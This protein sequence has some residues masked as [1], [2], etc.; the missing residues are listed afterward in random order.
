MIASGPSSDGNKSGDLKVSTGTSGSTGGTLKLI[1][2]HARDATGV[3]GGIEIVAGTGISADQYD[4]GNGGSVMIEAGAAKGEGANDTGGSTTIKGG[5]SIASSGG[6]V[7]VGSGSSEQ[8]VSG[9]ISIT[10]SDGIGTGDVSIG[11]GMASD[12]TSGTI[13]LGES[14]VRKNIVILFHSF[15]H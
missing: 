10:S 15:F 2:G 4:G 11:S 14:L 5:N 3:G 1:S 6:S 12:Q 13:Y 9:T 8:G 7:I